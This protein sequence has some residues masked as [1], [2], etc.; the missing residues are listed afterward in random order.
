MASSDHSVSKLSCWDIPLVT[1]GLL[2]PVAE[3]FLPGVSKTGRVEVQDGI[4]IVVA[5][6]VGPSRCVLFQPSVSL[7]SKRFS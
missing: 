6:A 1:R 3:C 7:L 4:G 5:L 2:E